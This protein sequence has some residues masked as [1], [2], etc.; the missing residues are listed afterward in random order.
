MLW[1]SFLRKSLNGDAIACMI[2]GIDGVVKLQLT[3]I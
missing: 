2:T 3:D 1:P